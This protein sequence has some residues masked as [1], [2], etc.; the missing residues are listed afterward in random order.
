MA[1][2]SGDGPGHGLFP[3]LREGVD[4]RLEG[5]SLGGVVGVV[6]DL[7]PRVLGGGDVEVVGQPAT[8]QLGVA[9]FLEEAVAPEAEGV[10]DGDPLGAEHGEGISQAGRGLDVAAGENGPP[11]V[12]ELDDQS[13]SRLGRDSFSP[14]PATSPWARERHPPWSERCRPGRRQPTTVP[15]V[16]F[17]TWRLTR[18]PAR[19]ARF[20]HPLVLLEEH[21]VTDAEGLGAEPDLFAELTAG[22]ASGPDH[23]VQGDDVGPADGQDGGGVIVVDGPPVLHQ[24]VPG[25]VDRA[26]DGD[27]AVLG[28][29]V[30]SPADVS[31]PESHQGVAFPL[32]VGRRPGG[33]WW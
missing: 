9:G 31:V 10:V 28:V 14:V 25:L 33:G 16:P 30:D 24:P 7:P 12:V 17:R 13:G 27:P 29:G 26:G 6:T 1:G 20:C 23:V 21:P 19:L 11:T 32:L 18:R 22:V 5:V 15:N 2:Q 3:G 8:R 4:E